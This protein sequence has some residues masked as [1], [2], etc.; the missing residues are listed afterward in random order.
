MA[1][2]G[3]SGGGKS[4]LLRLLLGFETAVQG[5]IYY[6]GQDLEALDLRSVRRQLGV[7]LQNGTLMAGTILS[8]IRGVS[9]ID[10]Q[11]AWRA[12]GLASLAEDISAMPMKMFTVL[13]PGGGTLS[14][15]QRQRLMI[16][17]A[18]ANDPRILFF[19]EATSALDNKSQAAVGESLG[20]LDATRIVIAH[21]LSTIRNAD[22]IFVLDG[23][24][25]VEAGTY[26]ELI[27]NGGL[28]EKLA[29]RQLV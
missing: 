19:D 1:L 23:G 24:R 2:V 13:G 18:V 4:T 14:G 12:A 27:A 3:P 11:Q 15:G 20:R 28:F 7:V 16:A 26:D 25:V 10:K 9:S 21:R 29:S 22:K 6:D 8:N 17:R 5:K